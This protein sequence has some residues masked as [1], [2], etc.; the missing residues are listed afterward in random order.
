MV[1]IHNVTDVF[2][3]IKAIPVD[4]VYKDGSQLMPLSQCMHSDL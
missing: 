1:T 2:K 3:L 4:I